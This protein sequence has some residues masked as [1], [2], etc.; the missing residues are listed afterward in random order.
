MLAKLLQRQLPVAALSF[1]GNPWI[2][3]SVTV[4][5]VFMCLN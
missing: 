3:K 4:L 2:G 5:M 1:S